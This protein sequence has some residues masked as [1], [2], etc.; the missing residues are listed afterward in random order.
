MHQ[1]LLTI[2]TVFGLYAL[3]VLSPGPS[4]ALVTRLAVS[5][6]RS[7]ALGATCGL[8]LASGFYAVLTMAG[9]SLVLARVSWLASV[10]QVAGGCYLVY[11]G[12]MA[13]LSGKPGAAASRPGA[14]SRQ[15]RQGLRDGIVVNLLNPKGIAFFLSLY[16]VAVPPGTALWAKAVILLG[17]FAIEVAWYGAAAVLLSS[18]SARA[19]YGRFGRWI[20]RGIGTVLAAIGLRLITEKL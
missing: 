1:D 20:E 6:S 8:A 11:L 10:V 14:T 2:A 4:F 15:V 19:A 13:W 17:S 9:L 18:P 5:G 16:A 12:C 7:A 3:A